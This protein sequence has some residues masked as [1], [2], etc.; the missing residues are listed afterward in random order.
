M[1]R[2]GKVAQSSAV[3][4]NAMRMVMR[5][6]AVAQTYKDGV[7]IFTASLEESAQLFGWREALEHRTIE[8]AVEAEA[9]IKE[10]KA[11]TAYLMK[12]C[13]AAEMDALSESEMA[14]VRERAKEIEEADRL[15]SVA[16][17]RF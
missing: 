13:N 7:S 10:F 1:G 15:M 2:A 14:A 11:M 12:I 4:A 17:I 9:Y 16:D 8:A 6:N 3:E 5:A